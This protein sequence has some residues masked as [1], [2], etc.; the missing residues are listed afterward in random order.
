[1]ASVDAIGTHSFFQERRRWWERWERKSR[2]ILQD[3]WLPLRHSRRCLERKQGR[4]S[5]KGEER[6]KEGQRWTGS[7][8]MVKRQDGKKKGWRSRKTIHVM[9]F[10]GLPRHEIKDFAWPMECWLD[11]FVFIFFECH[12]CCCC[13]CCFRCLPEIPQS[14]LH[15][16]CLGASDSPRSKDAPGFP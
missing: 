10:P 9:Q 7:S 8:L 1:M 13:C 6:V 5:K 16:P 14:V 4:E 12:R 2:E 3:P 11:F 15:Y